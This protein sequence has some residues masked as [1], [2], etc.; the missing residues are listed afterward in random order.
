MTPAERAESLM[1]EYGKVVLPDDVVADLDASA[2]EGA[3]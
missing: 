3:R 1:R 2:L